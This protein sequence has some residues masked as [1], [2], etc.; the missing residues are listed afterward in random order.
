[1]LKAEIWLLNDSSE[2]IK[3]T[4]IRVYLEA[5]GKRNRVYTVPTDTV[6][7]RTNKKF[8]EFSFEVTDDIPS[9]FKLIMEVPD[10]PEYNSEYTMFRR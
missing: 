8:G 3:P 2:S 9:V 6:D 5:D 1:M 7:P 4:D 10:H